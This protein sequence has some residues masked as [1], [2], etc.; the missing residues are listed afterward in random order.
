M[1]LTQKILAAIEERNRRNMERVAMAWS[2]QA[3]TKAKVR[4]N[5]SGEI[6]GIVRKTVEKHHQDE[7]AEGNLP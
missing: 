5:E 1:D 4:E 2:G 3:K 6:L 7:V